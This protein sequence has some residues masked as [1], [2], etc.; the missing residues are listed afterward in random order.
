LHKLKRPGGGLAL[1]HLGIHRNGSNIN[2]WRKLSL[3]CACLALF[4]AGE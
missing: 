4:R 2:C 3:G 1:Q